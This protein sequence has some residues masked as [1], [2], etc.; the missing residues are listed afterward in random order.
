MKDQPVRPLDYADPA[1]ENP[2]TRKDSI[3][4]FREPPKLATL[5]MSDVLIWVVSFIIVLIIFI[6]LVTRWWSKSWS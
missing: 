3:E 5:N 2:K 4:L 1:V 6:W